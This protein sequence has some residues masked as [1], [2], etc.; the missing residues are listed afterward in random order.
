MELWN[1]ALL[2]AGAVLVLEAVP[3]FGFPELLQRSAER[4]VQ[5]PPSRLR[6]GGLVLLFLGLAL[7][8]L[9]RVLLS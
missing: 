1:Q 9:R 2:I 7:L 5:I 8:G 4:L 3:Y 6:R